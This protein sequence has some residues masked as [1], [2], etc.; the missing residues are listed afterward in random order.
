VGHVVRGCAGP[1]AAGGLVEVAVEGGAFDAENAGD[2]FAGGFAFVV[3]PLRWAGVSLGRQPPVRATARP[4]RMLA[5]IM[6][7]T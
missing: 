1:A 7:R 6:N 3:E 2:L 5:T 4:S